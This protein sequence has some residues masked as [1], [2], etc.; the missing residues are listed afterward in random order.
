[1]RFR[2]LLFAPFLILLNLHLSYN[3]N[4]PARMLPAL[5][6]LLLAPL[7]TSHPVARWARLRDLSAHSSTNIR[8]TVS[9]AWFEGWSSFTASQVSWSKYSHVTYSFALVASRIHMQSG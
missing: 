4:L 5:A 9:A 3:S 7:A 8:P 2:D 6:M 1:V